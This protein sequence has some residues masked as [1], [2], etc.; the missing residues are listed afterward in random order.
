M[1]KLNLLQHDPSNPFQAFSDDGLIY[2]DS[3]A[4][5]PG[6]P[7]AAHAPQPP[8]PPVDPSA[9]LES[10]DGLPQSSPGSSR[11]GSIHTTTSTT[12][13]SGTTATASGSSTASP[14]VINITYDS[15]VSTAPSAF[16]TAMSSAVQY[17]ESQFSDP[18]S[19]NIHV[20]FGEVN[21]TALGSGQLG[22]SE[23]Y[24]NSYSYSQLTGALKADAKTSTDATAAASLPATDPT[25][26][27]YWVSTANAK[28][29]ALSGASTATDGYVGFSSSYAFDYNNAD[30]V[31]AG[32][33][34]F[35]GTAVH[36]LAEVMGKAMLTG[37]TIGTTPNGYYGLDLFHYA[38]PGV[39]DFSASTPGYFSIDGGVTNLGGFNTVSG[40]DAGDWGSGMG[41]DSFNAFS[42]S[43]VV[44]AVSNSDLTVLDTIG[45][46]RVLPAGP[47]VTIGLVADT[48]AS[49]TDKITNNDALTG[50][51]TAGVVVTLSEGSVTLGTAT[52]N[53]SGVWSFT[54]ASL[55]Q[56]ANTIAAS[57]VVSGTSVNSS[58]T[59]T[60]DTTPP[61]VSIGL[62]SMTGTT[63]T[64]ND[65]LQGTTD[66]NAPV[67]LTEGTTTLG[68]TTANSA[69]AWSFTPALT[70]GTH[71]IVATSQDLAGNVGS[72]SLSFTY[73]PPA[74]TGI[75]VAA[76][77]KQLGS[78]ATTG[79][80]AGSISLAGVTETGGV[81]GDSYSYTLGGAS[82]GLFTLTTS[83]NTGTLSTRTSGVAGAANG[84]AYLLSVTANDTTA[85]VSGPASPLAVIVGGAGADTISI[86]TLLGG[87]AEPAFIYGL[88]GNDA[89]N[90]AGVA[91]HLWIDGGAGADTM[92]G[93]SG[94]T[95]YLYGAT[96][97]SNSNAMDIVTNF[98]ASRDL[99]DLTGLNTALTYVGQLA[100]SA[101]SLGKHQVGWQQSGGNT[102]VYVNTANKTESLG[103]T[104]MKIELA[105]TVTL[106]G[107][108]ILHG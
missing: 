92:T 96:T 25:G 50:V 22:A 32:T 36:E 39:R 30:G 16:T 48:G 62:V 34:D 69:G 97:E 82:A 83:A 100:G 53:A 70:S 99:I 12:G 87:A 78:V 1:K 27:T 81:A 104:N 56:G 80:L 74:P 72:G 58:L 31:T 37:G 88:A 46:D 107:G 73:A 33:Y 61:V 42:N 66:P 84:K 28:A 24:L 103:A 21:G 43:G 60:Y 93:G 76:V 52:A 65:A 59:F 63:S 45:W 71:T 35:F 9:S 20:G 77:T 8:A 7:P 41:N 40:G 5:P 19:I 11:P 6:L 49:S 3:L 94:G 106:A 79:G 91:G 38:S 89:I 26:G 95:T 67:T 68:S 29:L 101:T 98:S 102:F 54:P 64:S 55:A 85:G 44:N 75:S 90:G 23:Y 57:A 13:G 86:G 14:F 18:V 17:L 15:S 2:L 10:T 47:S 108:N 51:T 105:G 4:L